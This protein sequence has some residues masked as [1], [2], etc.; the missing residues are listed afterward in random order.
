MLHPIVVVRRAPDGKL[1]DVLTRADPDA[2]PPD[3][4]AESWTRL[5]LAPL[6]VP[7]DKLEA[8][9]TGVLRDV[10]EIVAR[11]RADARRAPARSPTR[12]PASPRASGGTP[13]ADVASLLRWLVDGHLTFLGYRHHVAGPDGAL[14]PDIASGLGMLRDGT[15]RRRHR[16][17]PRRAR[18]PPRAAGDHPRQRAEPAEARAPLLPRRA[19]RSTA[20]AAA[21]ASTASSASLT[22]PALYESVLDIPVVERRVRGAI[23]RAGFPLESYSGPADAGGDLRPAP[24]GAVQRHRGAAARDRGRACSPSPSGARCASSC[25]PTRSAASSPAWSTCPRDQYTTSSRLAMADLLQRRLG[26]SVGGVHRAGHRSR[27][28]RWCTSRCRPTADAVGYAGVDVAGLQDELTEVVRTWDD[29]LLSEPGGAA[30]AAQL[31]GVPEAYKAITPPARA[32]EDLTR[33]AALAGPGR[34]RGAA[35]P[36][37]TARPTAAS[38]STSRA[39]PRRS[40]TCCRCCSSSASTSSTSVPRSSCA[41]TACACTSTTSAS[42]STTPPAR[43]SDAAARGRRRA[44][45]LRGVRRGVARRRRDRPVLRARAARGPAVARGRGAARL[46]PLRPPDRR[47]RTAPQYMADTLLAHPDV[48]RGAA[49]AVPGPVRPGAAATA[50]EAIEAARRWTCAAAIDAVTG[51]DADRILRGFL[52]DD[53]GDAAHQLVPRA[54]VLLVQDRPV[55]GAGHARAAAPVRDL[56]VLAA[57]RGRA[58]A[59]RRGRPRRPALVGPAAGLPHRDPRAWSRRRR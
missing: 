13:Q 35:V 41:P 40:P 52:G 12:S 8:K 47:A 58:P 57:G 19:A 3:A 43:R 50:S 5:E 39:P 16:L 7:P 30:L 18:R 56:R 51:L 42:G 33:I 9:L 44:R 37:P 20:R 11:R 32:V 25:A 1:A 14:R 2:P 54:P 22:V 6:A 10:R 31:A 38:P 59:L 36:A 29:R 26:G 48:A 28:W 46:R 45:V 4:L 49:G 27:G 21:P 55:A 23:H 24:R 17:H 15:P 34:L 53:H